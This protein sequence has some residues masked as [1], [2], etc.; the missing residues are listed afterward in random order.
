MKKISATIDIFSLAVNDDYEVRTETLRGED[1]WVLPVVMMV[2]GV[3]HG[4][5]G[6]LLYTAKELGKITAAWNGIPV[7]VQHPQLEGVYT[8]ANLPE[9]ADSV[10]GYVY[11]TR[12][13]GNKLKL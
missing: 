5:L 6:P 3:H 10:V 9:L 7:T 2:E 13:D 8:S 1:H 4:S 11:H 12:M